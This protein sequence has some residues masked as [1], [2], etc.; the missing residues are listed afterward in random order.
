MNQEQF[1]RELRQGLAG[2][3]AHDIDD[4]TADYQSYFDE[5][6]SAGRS[7]DDVL[8]AHGDP[9]RLA[10]ELRAEMGFRQW[11]DRHSPGSFWNAA[12]AL[13][14]LAAIDIVILVPGVIV[15]G[16]VILIL[17]FVLSLFGVIGIGTLLD[18]ISGS[19]DPSEGSVAY[20]VLR[21]IAL[22]AASVG[23]G[24]VIVLGLKRGMS[25]LLRYGRHHY[26]LL[27]PGSLDA[28][29]ATGQNA[30]VDKNTGGP[31]I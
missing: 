18:L 14:G 7:L 6:E 26:R 23:G 11:E 3:P 19:T 10:R 27:R 2:I 8:A 15:L 20:L 1:I 24:I 29:P 17:F 12:L 13:G 21:S 31:E 5:A 4:I 9:R 30:G 22:L 25:Q 28:V 16:A